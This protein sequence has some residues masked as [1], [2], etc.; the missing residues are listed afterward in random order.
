LTGAFLAAGA[1]FFA[2]VFF[3]AIAFRNALSVMAT[4]V[5]F[6]AAGAG[7]FFAVAM[8]ILLC[9]LIEFEIQIVLKS[10]ISDRRNLQS[11]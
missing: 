4:D 6:F 7:V 5:V 11:D 3:A 1:D 2:A 8:D 10:I 9:W